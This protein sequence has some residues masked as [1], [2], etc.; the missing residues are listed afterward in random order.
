VY[1]TTVRRPW[2]QLDV[3]KFRAEL[4]T[5]ALCRPD[6][7]SVF[8]VDDL[9]KLYDTEINA[10]LDRLV[11]PRSITC[12]RR[13]TDPWFDADCRTAK[14][15]TRKLERAAHRA[16]PSDAAAVNAAASAWY[17]QRRTYRTLLHQSS[18]SRSD[19]LRS[20][21]SAQIHDYCGVLSTTTSF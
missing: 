5:S 3:S 9:A 19:V 12:R 1:S 4:Q 13:P 17:A 6:T 8:D 15:Q 11:P 2:R 21:L 7:W 10:I 20:T 16:D 18:M 14:R